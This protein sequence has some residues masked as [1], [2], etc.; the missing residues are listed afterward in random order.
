MVVERSALGIYCILF[1]VGC[2]EKVVQTGPKAVQHK[3]QC[4]EKE[5]REVSIKK[6]GKQTADGYRSKWTEAS[7]AAAGQADSI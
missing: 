4:R 2:T 7:I 3:A 6:K 5:T 1:G